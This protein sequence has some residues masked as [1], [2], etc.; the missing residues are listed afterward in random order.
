MAGRP[1]HVL[2]GVSGAIA[3]YRAADVVRG[4][5]KGGAE[6]TVA[7]TANAERFVTPF[8]LAN[9]SGRPVVTGQYGPEMAD[10]HHV[11]LA[12]AVDLLLVAPATA[13][14]L[15]RLAHG[16]ADD[17]LTTFALATP[18]PVLLAP[19][20]NPRMWAHPA[21]QANVATLRAR[22]ASFVGPVEGELAT[23]HAGLGR[24]AEVDAIVEEALRIIRGG[25]SLRGQRWLVTAGPTQEDLDLARTLT[26]RSTGKMGFAVAAVARA[27]GAEV[28]LVSGP[29]EVAPPPGVEVVRVRSAEDMR[30]AVL[31]RLEPVDVV[32]MAAAVADFRPEHSEPRKM[33]KEEAGEVTSLTLVRTADILAEVGR[34]KGHR[35][36]VGFAAE[37]GDLEARALDKLRKK[38][39]DLVVANDIS[40]SD[41]G[42]AAEENEVMLI[43]EGSREDV[44]KRPK[45]EIA[46]RIA[47]RI[48][49]LLA[50]RRPSTG[51][52]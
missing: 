15:A 41:R 1:P 20:M 8:L 2:I 29:T 31:A 52:S 25:G 16:L 5:R 21:T 37:D 17:F 24:L 7:L 33:K 34:L 26:N 27:R 32:V 51:P 50:A 43:A 44:S 36:L 11:N 4:L 22:G 12:F 42:F 14:L 46:E 28:V 3:A 39:L 10:V 30:A 38:Q 13:D 47:D 19:A 45:R 49:V 9:L 35:V 48:E 23:L 40:A 18:A 6:V